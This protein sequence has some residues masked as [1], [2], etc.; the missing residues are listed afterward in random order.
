L[1]TISLKAR[2]AAAQASFVA[3]EV[4]SSIL[5][6]LHVYFIACFLFYFLTYPDVRTVKAFTGESFEKKR[7][8]EKIKDSLQLSE[9]M[10]V[11]LGVLQGMIF[12]FL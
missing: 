4:I 12:L 2:N 11:F 1:K 3:T 6:L 9:R 7:F 5:I 10:G 8:S